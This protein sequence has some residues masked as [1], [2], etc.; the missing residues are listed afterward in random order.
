MTDTSGADPRGAARI[1]VFGG[2]FN[3]I[4]LGHLRAAEEIAEALYLA[5]VHFVVSAA[6]PHK[7]TR[8][9]IAAED[10]FAMV[11][12]ACAGNPRF[13]PSRVELERRGPSYTIDTLRHFAAA[14]GRANLYF[15]TGLDAFEEIGVWK[16]ARAMVM[17]YNF[18]VAARPGGQWERVADTLRAIT[19]RGVAAEERSEG[20]HA[21]RAEGAAGVTLAMRTTALDISSTAIR[22]RLREGRSI[23][24]LAPEPVTRYLEEHRI[25]PPA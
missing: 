16:E 12:L 24:Y 11:T 23:R 19:G 9:L 7:D 22:R 17:E 15:I 1:G 14:H 3:P 25:A 8:G 5:R 21:F 4:H 18:A 20:V 2:A 10:R 13:A 6:P